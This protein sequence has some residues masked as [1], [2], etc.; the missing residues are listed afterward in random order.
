MACIRP[1]GRI[2]ARTA[3]FT[4][5]DIRWLP[6]V[7]GAGGLWQ[8]FERAVLSES[9]GR[10]TDLRLGLMEAERLRL[11]TGPAAQARHA[12]V[13]DLAALDPVY[14]PPTDRQAKVD[15]TR[16]V[17]TFFDGDEPVRLARHVNRCL[18][19]LHPFRAL[20]CFRARPARAA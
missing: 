9:G 5:L 8:V 2:I 18:P 11:P 16:Q 3:A 4:G 1:F 12:P 17:V 15:L 13:V 7:V 19:G 20:P 10:L 6:A 14:G